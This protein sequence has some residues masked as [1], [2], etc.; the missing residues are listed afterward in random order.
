MALTL[1]LSVTARIEGRLDATDVAIRGIGPASACD[2]I[3]DPHPSS[4]HHRRPFIG[5]GNRDR[6]TVAI[7]VQRSTL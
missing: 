4:A 5:G 1:S 3:V 2:T 6:I 7:F